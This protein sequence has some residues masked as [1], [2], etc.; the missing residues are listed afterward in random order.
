MRVQT[1]IPVPPRFQLVVV[2][3]LALAVAS[4]S[5]AE[6][7]LERLRYNHPG[8]VVDLGVGLWAWPLPMDYDGDGDLDLVVSCPDV[9]FNGIYLFENPGGDRKQPVFRPPVR[10]AAGVTNVRPSYVGGGVRVLA[11]G[12]EFANFQS[13]RL[14]AQVSIY[15]ET[16]L[17]GPGSRLRA[18]Q[19]QYSDYDGDGAIDLMVGVEDWAAYGWDNA[20]DATGGW[21]R[22]PLH[23]YVFLIRNHGSTAT[24]AYDSPRKLEAGGKPIDVFGMPSPCLADFDGDGDLDLICGEFLDGFTYF[25]NVGTRKSPVFAVG[26][27]LADESGKV[28]RMHLQMIVPVAI[29]WDGDGDTDL[30]CGDEDGRVALVEHTGRVLDGS[31]RFKPPVYF[32]QQAED[33]K[34][35]ALVTPSAADWDG[36]GDTDLVCGDSAGNLGWFENLGG[37]AGHLPRWAAPRLLEVDGSPIRILAGPNGSIQGPC[38]AKWGYTQPCVADWDG[39]GDLDVVVNSIWGKVVWYRNAG[40]RTAARLEPA[41]PIEV[42]WAGSPPKPAWTWWTPTSRELATQW[43]TTPAVVDWNR[44]G[45]P[46]LVMLD[47]EGYLAFFERARD[48]SG[49]PALLKPG[50]RIFRSEPASAFDSR[51]TPRNVLAGPLRL[52]VGAAGASGRRTLTFADW[53]GD[54]KVDLVVDSSNATFMRSENANADG[55]PVTFRDGPALASRKLAGHST[56]PAIVDWDRDGVPDLVIGAED[57]RLYFLKHAR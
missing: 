38:E 50:R 54:G 44:D 2:P 29:D 39:D 13:R 36:D 30:V 1:S 33:L 40:T 22:G 17:V 48:T 42:D 57:G 3:L 41:R 24:P 46:D 31:P 37:E 56:C 21:T 12:K 6:P 20:F 7:T 25:E 11:P 28:V 27:R 8:L 35:G 47:H 45:L 53:D 49:S 55:G 23:G 19:W 10:I 14:E 18:N 9:P 26:R 34:F 43:R 52:N 5:A 4:I 32:K 16:N 51:H 15:P